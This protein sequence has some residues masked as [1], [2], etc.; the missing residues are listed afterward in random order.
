MSER[1][2]E[3]VKILLVDDRPSNLLALKSLLERPDYELVLAQSGDEA[4]RA[5]LRHDFAVIL[6]DVAMPGMDGFE[7][8]ALIK[9]RQRTRE[10]P[11]LFV[12]ASVYDMQS[13]F[14]GYT[15]GA[16]DYLQKPI[17]PHQVRAKVAVFV[18]L[19][20]Q[21]RQIE[22]QAAALRASAERER[23]L[24]R[25]RAE[26]S[27]AQY[28]ITVEEAPVG[29]GEADAEGKWRRANPRLTAILGLDAEALVG[30]PLVEAVDPSERA[31]VAEVLRRAVTGETV[32]HAGARF[33]RSDGEARLIDLTVAPVRAATPG[34][35]VQRLL[36]VVDDVT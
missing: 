6:L 36:A 19:Y 8:A 5:L 35:G 10:V 16:V 7:T 30:R 23:E 13:I 32:R 29:I 12:T 21:A 18:A 26:D 33:R 11:I 22:R 2:D 15:V 1:S 24:L 25:R 31:A 9:K 28:R 20:R 3:K 27:E 14:Q 17:D 34:D 4:L